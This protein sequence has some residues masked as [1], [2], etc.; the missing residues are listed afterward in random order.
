[1]VE[2]EL[3]NIAERQQCNVDKLV[4][5]VKENGRILDEMEVS[6]Q[7]MM[8]IIRRCDT[9]TTSYFHRKTHRTTSEDA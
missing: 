2:E 1:V 8:I 4:N 6:Y 7:V 5:L 9:L 3:R